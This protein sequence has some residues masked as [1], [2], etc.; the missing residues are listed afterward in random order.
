VISFLHPPSLNVFDGLSSFI[1]AGNNWNNPYALFP[2]KKNA[3]YLQDL[4]RG[5]KTISII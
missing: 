5:Y 1:Q 2:N 4:V 3:T